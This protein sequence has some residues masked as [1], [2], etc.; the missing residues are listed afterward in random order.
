M[1]SIIILI[2]LVRFIGNLAIAKG[3]KPGKWKIRTI[4]AWLLGDL[5]GELIIYNF[6]GLNLLLIMIFGSAMGYLGFLMVKQQ[7][8]NLPDSEEEF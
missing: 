5:S 3:E 6:F 7:L 2:F 8:D 4:G 1:I